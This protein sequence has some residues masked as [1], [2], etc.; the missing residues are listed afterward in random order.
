MPIPGTQDGPALQVRIGAMRQSP[1]AAEQ[2]R[3]KARKDAR[4]QGD[5]VAQETLEAADSVLILTTLTDT[6]ADAAEILA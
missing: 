3:R 5:T 2:A 1:P 6:A 4:D